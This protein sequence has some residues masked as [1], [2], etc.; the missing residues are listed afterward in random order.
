MTRALV[1]GAGSFRVVE[2]SEWDPAG[3]AATGFE[4]LA[5]VAPAVTELARTIAR[6]QGLSVHGDAPLLHPSLA[7]AEKA[8]Q[9]LRGRAAGEALI[10]HFSG[11]GVLGNSD[12]TLYLAV[13]DSESGSLPRTAVRVNTWLDEVEDTPDGAP[14]LFLLDVCGA[15]RAAVYQLAQR[16]RVRDRKSWVI[17]AC[18]ED[19]KAYKAH[20]T[21]ATVTVLER[22]R[23]GVL[24]V[25]P[26]LAYIP[27]E[28]LAEEIDRELA[29]LAERDGQGFGQTVVRTPRL[30]AFAEPPPFFPNPAYAHNLF[31]QFQRRRD[32]ALWQ[33]AAEADPGLDPLHFVSRASGTSSQAAEECRFAGR[34]EQRLRI[35]AWLD[36]PAG[37]EP[38]L[39]VVTGGPGAGKS[40]LLGVTLCLAH[41]DLQAVAGTIRSRIPAAE[42]PSVH[43][44]LAAVHTRERSQAEILSSLAGQLSLG[45]PPAGGPWTT[46]AVLER[47]R[48]APVPAVVVL[49]ALDEALRAEELVTQVVL[50]LV[51]ATRDGRPLCRVLIGTRP[52]RGF[53]ALRE[54]LRSD[55]ELI[56]LDR[57]PAPQLAADLAGYLEDAL[58]PHASPGKAGA[59]T[60]VARQAADRLTRARHHGRFLLAVLFADY[61]TRLRDPLDARESVERLPTDLPGMLELHLETLTEQDPWLRPV[62][63]AVA[64]ARGEGM[65]LDALHTVATASAPSV[66]SGSHALAPTLS[67]TRRALAAATFYLRTNTGPDG[68]Q[69]YRFFH[70][71]IVEHMRKDQSGQGTTGRGVAEAVFARL[72]DT[73]PLAPD[74]RSRLWHLASPYVRRHLVEHA[75][76][77]GPQAVNALLL[78]P[79]FLVHADPAATAAN[80]HRATDRTA[81]LHARILDT[82][83]KHHPE[84]TPEARRRLLELDAIRWRHPELAHAVTDGGPPAVRPVWATNANIHPAL[85]RAFNRRHHV[86]AMATADIDGRA[87][88]LTAEGSQVWL[89]DLAEGAER[90]VLACGQQVRAVRV[91]EIGGRPHALTAAGTEMRLWDLTDGTERYNVI[92][93]RQVQEVRETEIDGRPHALVTAGKTVHVRDLAEG[94]HR[95]DLRHG[96]PVRLVDPLTVHQRP[97][98]LTY[99]EDGLR[100]WDLTDG[101]ERRVLRHLRRLRAVAGVEI[102]KR[103]HAITTAENGV[104]V[105]DLTDGALRHS[106]GH[107]DPVHG[108]TA[109]EL[110]G[111]PHAL[112]TSVNVVSVWD[113]DTG[114]LRHELRHKGPARVA[115]VVEVLR[116]TRVLTV[117]GKSLHAWDLTGGAL[118]QVFSDHHGNVQAAAFT[119]DD[120][121]PYALTTD[122]DHVVRVWDLAGGIS[123]HEAPVRTIAA[124]EVRGRPYALTTAGDRDA[125]VWDLDNGI[126]VHTLRSD[127]PIKSAAVATVDG[128]A[129]GLTASG[130]HEVCLWD[131]A[132]GVQAQRL[133][134]D[135]PV[136]AVTVSDLRGR[137]HA[138][139]ICSSPHH[140]VHVWS[141]PDAVLLHT[142]KLGKP[143]DSVLAAE[144]DGRPH[145][146]I[147]SGRWLEARDLVDGSTR[148]ARDLSRRRQLLAA[149]IDGTAHAL[150]S[151]GDLFRLIRLSDGRLVKALPVKSGW[152]ITHMEV[153]D[154]DGRAHALICSGKKV[155]VWDMPHRRLVMKLAHDELVGSAVVTRA[156]GRAR[157]VTTSGHRVCLWDAA[158]GERDGPPLIVPHPAQWLLPH[159]RGFVVSFGPELA[160]FSVP[161]ESESR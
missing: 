90:H 49:D 69:L 56:D 85:R 114:A 72:R 27:V 158:T 117:S 98:A 82:S 11:H 41:K 53:P 18:T 99:A 97:H 19:E 146:V 112:T 135:Q 161:G 152:P 130:E 13:H 123:H 44:F 31:D 104:R 101:G 59:V 55:G 71:A 80:A 63:R 92:H 95:C 89:W 113:L 100:L 94:V 35:N 142:R 37:S 51:T 74:G 121:R 138:L 73:V 93:D 24:D 39:L 141:L 4:P 66:G 28:T 81:K 133:D 3:S 17:A 42:R 126:L 38:S 143:V 96:E 16:L 151:S 23:D 103:P 102:G 70:H 86:R 21:Q 5:C 25:S 88:A 2:Q 9:E 118:H 149:D 64:C 150:M 22:L 122:V 153:A 119:P 57:V 26:A 106:L 30:E 52:W 110:N 145:A 68:R 127:Q 91:I 105:W 147:A 62:L 75:V 10:V 109:F 50:P 134:H 111:R 43:P 132:D 79:R 144:I 67:D 32:S 159:P 156:G 128:R 129:Y 125:R 148:W 6:L 12:T 54:R 139:T 58:W 108:I 76:A 47:L 83:I 48:D 84:R 77:A 8:W 1:V 14:T 154:I 40:A 116:R 65:P 33:F 7:E 87:H 60:E 34:R 137:P 160:L 61:L 120:E 131:L 46:Q 78:D 36:D 155:W 157:V 45:A 15:G 115:G 136:S 140:R 29:R 107:L 124:A 20:F